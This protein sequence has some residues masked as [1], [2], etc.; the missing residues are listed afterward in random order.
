M[1]REDPKGIEYQLKKNWTTL[2]KELNNN[3]RKTKQQCN[4]TQK[5]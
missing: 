4:K 3:S 2:Q 5:H 1:T